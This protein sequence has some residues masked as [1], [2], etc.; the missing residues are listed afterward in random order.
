MTDSSDFHEA[1]EAF[2]AL[3]YPDYPRTEKLRDWNS[4]LLDLDGHIAGY[5][6]QVNDG[7][8]NA[9]E[10]PDLGSLVL[11]VENL[12]RS[13]EEIHPEGEKESGLLNEYRVYVAA[14]ERLVR[15]LASLAR[16]EGE[17]MTQ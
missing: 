6:I 12:C 1:L 14:L 3:P 5:A 9:R 8:L 11:E 15:E 4:F 2:M 7:D 16:Q 13:I 10:V 17:S